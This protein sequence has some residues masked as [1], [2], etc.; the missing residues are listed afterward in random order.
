MKTKLGYIFGQIKFKKGSFMRMQK[1][2]GEKFA[3]EY[4]AVVAVALLWRLQLEKFP[5]RKDWPNK[6][7]DFGQSRWIIQT[8]VIINGS[9]GV[10]AHKS[11]PVFVAPIP[12]EK[13]CC[14]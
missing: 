1:K 4:A 10:G 7:F 13:E 5:T 6:L 11:C 3:H 14:C 9:S 2:I 8:V 12:R